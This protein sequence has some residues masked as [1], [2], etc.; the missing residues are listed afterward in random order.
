M[1]NKNII[2]TLAVGTSIAAAVVAL[3]KSDMAAAVG[4]VNLAYLVNIAEKL[5]K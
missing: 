3:L 2:G 5:D 1:K 4:F